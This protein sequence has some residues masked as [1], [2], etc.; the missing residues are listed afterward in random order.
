MIR[1]ILD[2]QP[3]PKFVFNSEMIEGEEIFSRDGY[4]ARMP[5]TWK[6]SLLLP[7]G[8]TLYRYSEERRPNDDGVWYTR[9][10]DEKVEPHIF[11]LEFWGKEEGEWEDRWD[12]GWEHVIIR[13]PFHTRYLLVGASEQYQWH[14]IGEPE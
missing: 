14:E 1:D 10:I 5:S 4:R 11:T 12:R 3:K 9:S 7:D 13:A 2:A 8:R 6:F